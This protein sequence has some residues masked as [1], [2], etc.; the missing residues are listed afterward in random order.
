MRINQQFDKCDFWRSNDDS[1]NIQLNKYQQ[2]R[3][4]NA[5]TSDFEQMWQKMKAVASRWVKMEIN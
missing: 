1:R 5:I 3:N 2:K 4:F